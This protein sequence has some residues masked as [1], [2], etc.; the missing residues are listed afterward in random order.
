MPIISVRDNEID[1]RE[2]Q[3]NNDRKE[4]MGD[5]SYC[6]SV[7]DKWFWCAFKLGFP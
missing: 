7:R 5:T 6:E 4:E 2:R 3:K 1:E